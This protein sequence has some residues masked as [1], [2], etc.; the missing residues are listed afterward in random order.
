MTAACRKSPNTSAPQSSN[1][2]Q[3][4]DGPGAAVAATFAD[5][6]LFPSIAGI[7]PRR[8]EPPQRANSGYMHRSKTVIIRS[9]HQRWTADR[10]AR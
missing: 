10:P 5:R 8:R 1:A 9:P 2:L 7:S 4:R 3:V 6:P